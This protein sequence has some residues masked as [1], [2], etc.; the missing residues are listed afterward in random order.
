MMLRAVSLD[1]TRAWVRRL[2]HRTV[3][4]Q[5]MHVRG[6]CA[7]AFDRSGS[8]QRMDKEITIKS[9]RIERHPSHLA[10]DG[11]QCRSRQAHGAA[12]ARLELPTSTERLDKTDPHLIANLFA[13]FFVPLPQDM[14]NATYSESPMWRV[15]WHS[16]L[17]ALGLSRSAY[18]RTTRLHLRPLAWGLRGD[19]TR[20]QA[21]RSHQARDRS[22][23]DRRT[24]RPLPSQ[25]PRGRCRQRRPDRRRP[26][27]P[28][29]PRLAEASVSPSHPRSNRLLNGTTR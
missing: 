15:A 27:S 11:R 5:Q 9:S 18:Q 4:K 25:G 8:R 6:Y 22:H 26:Q 3:L 13:C 2:F 12:R 24:S 20:A 28:P 14:I 16:I 21:P 7:Q 29:H 10:G 19:Q 23:E 1:T 17:L